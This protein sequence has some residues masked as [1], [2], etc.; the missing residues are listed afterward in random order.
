MSVVDD[1]PL[2]PDHDKAGLVNDDDMLALANDL[3]QSGS[4][5]DLHA[6]LGG[7]SLFADVAP[8]PDRSLG[9]D[10]GLSAIFPV[11]S[12]PPT[13]PVEQFNG[14]SQQLDPPAPLASPQHQ[15]PGVTVE[16][17]QLL[18]QPLTL[19]PYGQHTLAIPSNLLGS[20]LAP[21]QLA[22]AA[23]LSGAVHA[24]LTSQDAG[25]PHVAGLPQ[26]ALWQASAGSTLPAGLLPPLSGFVTIMDTAGN[27]ILVDA[28]SASALTGGAMT[29]TTGGAPLALAAPYGGTVHAGYSLLGGAP[30]Q[31]AEADQFVSQ[32]QQ[33]TG[34]R[35]R[36]P[37]P[38]STR[39][40]PSGPVDSGASAQTG[41][42]S[43]AERL[44]ALARELNASLSDEQKRALNRLHQQ[45]KDAATPDDAAAF[46]HQFWALWYTFAP[47]AKVTEL[48]NL[49]TG[50][51]SAGSDPAPKPSYDA[52]G[53][54]HHPAMFAPPHPAPSGG[55][56]HHLCADNSS[57]H[58][59]DA[60]NAP[61]PTS[62]PS[63]PPAVAVASQDS[64]VS[65]SA[66]HAARGRRKRDAVHEVAD[67]A[68]AKVAKASR[69]H[70]PCDLSKLSEMGD[71][72]KVLQAYD[73][74]HAAQL[75]GLEA[76]IRSLEAHVALEAAARCSA[77]R[78]CARLA[79]EAH[80]LRMQ[81][82]HS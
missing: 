7:C 78:E 60:D 35:T 13:L 37:V 6:V 28:A 1:F 33:P 22:D 54:D 41:G 40:S 32:Q 10:A 67:S 3:L 18:S 5:P 77:E 20:Q 69:G 81:L 76:T 46:S 4:C 73:A 59:L 58:E 23:A 42:P 21:G 31:Q 79:D 65:S 38:R 64:N 36:P 52:S 11:V 9:L 74:A 55:Y 80:H 62:V 48:K 45:A 39:S 82:G 27:A 72:V 57:A 17:Q 53:D 15:N 29:V 61:T 44:Q 16:Q 71:V 68:A 70:T 66:N 2:V 25:S 75:A 30:Q 43:D 47:A 50:P 34:S 12:Q 14:Q 24:M 51:P 56:P 63:L 19:V 8:E 49:M 26:P